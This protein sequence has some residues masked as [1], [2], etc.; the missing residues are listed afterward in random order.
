VDAGAR[1]RG[2]KRKPASQKSLK[3]RDL[4]GV[5]VAAYWV[6]NCGIAVL[7]RPARRM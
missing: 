7:A 4:F 3:G 5:C 2:N 6:L 1:C